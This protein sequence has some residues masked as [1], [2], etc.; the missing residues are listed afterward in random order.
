[1]VV[2][3]DADRVVRTGN[4]D[5]N[6]A[7]RYVAMNEACPLQAGDRGGKFPGEAKTLPLVE[8]RPATVRSEATEVLRSAIVRPPD[9]PRKMGDD[10]YPVDVD[11]SKPAEGDAV[12]EIGLLC[13]FHLDQQSCPLFALPDFRL[14]DFHKGGNAFRATDALDLQFSLQ[15]V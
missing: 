15:A 11:P 4:A 10:L 9:H 7:G 1:V 14:E 6:V 13:Q 2:T 12:E 3:Q 5:E 8:S